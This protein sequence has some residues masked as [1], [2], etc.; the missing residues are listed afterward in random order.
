MVK[1]I[2]T[3]KPRP[4]YREVALENI[5]PFEHNAKVHPKEQ[6]GAIARSIETLGFNAPLILDARLGIIAGHGRFE[7]AKLLKMKTVPCV[8]LSHLSEEEKRAY[9]LADNKLSEGGKWDFSMLVDEKE[10]F[11]QAG[12]DA[13]I[14]GFDFSLDL[15]K[16]SEPKGRGRGRSWV[17]DMDQM[18][19]VLTVPIEHVD[20]VKQ[21]LANGER[22]TSTAMGRGLLRR[23]GIIDA[24]A[25][26][27]V[28][29][30]AP[31]PDWEEQ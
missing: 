12:F 31:A 2:S 4:E 11:Q 20:A 18:D 22:Y 10:F 21:Y 15:F 29:E 25:R 17:P 26:A 13:T 30:A 6:I 23:M 9:V 16:D 28:D 19:L 3:E 8:I 5:T 7:A 24:K 14:T 1:K 27:P